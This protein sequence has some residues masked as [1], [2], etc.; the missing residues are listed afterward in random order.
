MEFFGD[1][2]SPGDVLVAEADDRIVG[3]V[4]VVPRYRR[5][6]A[7]EH[8]YEIRGLAVCPQSQREGIGRRLVQGA[9]E[10]ARTRG[11]RRLTL[12]VLASNLIARALYERCGFV[13]EG[14]RQG[15]FYLRGQ[16]VDDLVLALDLQ[17]DAATR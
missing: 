17:T 13:L 11:A 1:R 8:V 7:G 5:L 9:A 4:T 6:S 14:V 12:N 15:E 3:Y 10:L 16:F 2:V